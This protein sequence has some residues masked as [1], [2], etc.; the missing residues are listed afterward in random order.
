LTPEAQA[1]AQK[2]L[3]FKP[4]FAIMLDALIVSNKIKAEIREE[5][6][7]TAKLM[8]KIAEEGKQRLEAEKTRLMAEA[9][10]AEA[11]HEDIIAEL[12]EAMPELQ[13]IEFQIN[14]ED[15]TYTPMGPRLFEDAKIE[16]STDEAKA[17]L[18]PKTNPESEAEAHARKMVED[19]LGKFMGG[20]RQ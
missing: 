6:D 7:K 16:I 1:I 11:K 2:L 3:M 19:L 20:T 18:L 17:L 14:G 8:R 10:E 4:Q 13:T 15:G 9:D 5:L 12:R